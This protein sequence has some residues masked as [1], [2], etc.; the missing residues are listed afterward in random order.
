MA[1]T[2]AGMDSFSNDIGPEQAARR[3]REFGT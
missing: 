3:L 2:E 1:G